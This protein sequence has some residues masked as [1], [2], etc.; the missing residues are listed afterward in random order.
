M[1]CEQSARVGRVELLRRAAQRGFTLVEMAIVLVIIGLIIGG[2]L[3]GQEIVSNARVKSQVAQVDGVK[4][5]VA[6][7]V[8]EYNYYPGDDPNAGTQL[9]LASSLSGASGDGDGFVA[10]P[11]TAAAIFDSAIPGTE[12]GFAWLDMQEARLIEGV[13]VP[14]NATNASVFQNLGKLSS[15]YIWFGDWSNVTTGGLKVTNKMILL[16]GVAGMAIPKPGA[17][18]ADASQ[19][20]TKY[21][22]GLPTTGLIIAGST[23]DTSNCCGTAGCTSASAQYGLSTT[24]STASPYC[25]IEWVVQ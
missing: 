15:S 16:S 6:T 7:F 2:I 4:A 23:S 24:G 18:T 22:D 25:V 19:I 1:A 9:N 21:D 12:M 11:G 20:D 3:K 8:D 5:A 13:A 14:V 10:T 17:R